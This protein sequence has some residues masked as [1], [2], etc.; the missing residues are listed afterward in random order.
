[1]SE[2]LNSKLE[3]LN[4]QKIIHEYYIQLNNH[5]HNGGHDRE[6]VKGVSELD[7]LNKLDN[8]Q[9]MKKVISGF[10]EL[11]EKHSKAVLEDYIKTHSDESEKV[12]TTYTGK[13]EYTVPDSVYGGA[14]IRVKIGG[15]EPNKKDDYGRVYSDLEGEIEKRSSAKTEVSRG[16]YKNKYGIGQKVFVIN[17]NEIS[18]CV[19]QDISDGEDGIEYVA[20]DDY[21]CDFKLMEKEVFTTVDE[22]LSY[23]HELAK[24]L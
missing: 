13:Y 24:S 21:G 5:V 20:Y 18:E 9:G 8:N 15:K 3:D 22:L 16:T 1:M 10:K 2:I 12:D 23:L 11:A 6:I 14:G 19:I 4:S 7:F 17:Q